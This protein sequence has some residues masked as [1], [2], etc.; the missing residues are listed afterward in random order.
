MSDR[1]YKLERVG[2]LLE[3]AEAKLM[4]LGMTALHRRIGKVTDAIYYEIEY[5][6]DTEEAEVIKTKETIR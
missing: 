1:T 3:E 4:E 6:G 2:L 5:L